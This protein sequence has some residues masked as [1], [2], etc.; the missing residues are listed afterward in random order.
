MIDQMDPLIGKTLSS[1][2]A[3]TWFCDFNQES[4]KDTHTHTHI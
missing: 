2:S 4:I 3:A 1:Q